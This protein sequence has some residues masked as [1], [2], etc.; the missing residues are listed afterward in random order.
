MSEIKVSVVDYG[1]KFL[2]LRY[3]DPLTGKQKTKSAETANRKDAI[4]AAGKWQAELREGRHKPAST[5]TWAEF[6]DRY[7]TDGLATHADETVKKVLTTFKLVE[8][9]HQPTPKHL[10][11][12]STE[13]VGRWITALLA[14]RAPATAAMYGRHLRAALRW[15]KEQGFIHEAPR[16]RMPKQDKGKLMKGRPIVLE[17]HERILGAVSKLVGEQEAAEW[18]R[19]LNGL[20]WSGL[21]LGEALRLSWE[22]TA[23]VSVMMQPGYRPAIRFKA[24]GQKSRR[25][26]LWPCPP[27]F[28]ELLEAIP[29]A[30]RVGYVFKMKARSM[31]FGR[32][33][34]DRVSKIIAEA[35][36]KAG[37]LVDESTEKHATAHDYRRAFG[38]RWSKRVMP[39]ML[40]RMMRHREIGTTMS[41]YVTQDADEI[42]D[43]MWTAYR[44][45]VGS[46]SGNT[47]PKNAENP[48]E[49]RD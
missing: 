3:V 17:E 27:E 49:T 23:D 32:L 28:A 2:Q 38:T 46:T 33:S 4:K 12:L 14:S 10:R 43:A 6:R 24:S 47:S 25:A 22:T 42:A 31:H 13:S 8:E 41:F 15:A 48:A 36:E 44:R 37:V 35:G 29:E 16:L 11:D 18:E 26:E 7:E 21:R 34:Q 19:F 1:R 5:I 9:L 30:E 45:D 39:A 40:Q 20:W